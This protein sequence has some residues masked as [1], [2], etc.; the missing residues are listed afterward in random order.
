MVSFF[1]ESIAEPKSTQEE[2]QILSFLS[3]FFAG[4]RVTCPIFPHANYKKG[5]VTKHVLQCALYHA[6]EI[7]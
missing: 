7:L 5:V 4:K 6:N 3:H 1:V 2:I